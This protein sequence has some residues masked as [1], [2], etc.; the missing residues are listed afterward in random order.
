MVVF[1]II[2]LL[3]SMNAFVKAAGLV[4]SSCSQSCGNVRAFHSLLVLNLIATF[5]IRIR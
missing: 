5:P 2:V 3:G 4:N 1:Q